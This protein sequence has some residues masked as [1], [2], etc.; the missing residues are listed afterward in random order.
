MATKGK[1]ATAKPAAKPAKPIDQK[2]VGK[3]AAQVRAEH[4]AGGDVDSDG[5]IAG[6]AVAVASKGFSGFKLVKRITLPTLNP[7]IDQPYV[8]KIIDG[9]RESSYIDP[10][11]KKKNDKPATICEC[12]DMQTGIHYLWLVGEVV[13]KNLEE[14]YPDEGY[15]GLLFGVR[16]LPKRPGK[17]YHDYDIGEFA[18]E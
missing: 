17:R 5:V 18:A 1:A 9:F 13:K 16:K 3:T 8:L 6:T 12:V 14:N 4:L 11:P 10:D 2:E 7:G 15:I